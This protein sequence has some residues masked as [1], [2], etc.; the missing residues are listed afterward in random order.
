MTMALSDLVTQFERETEAEIRAIRS[1]GDAAAAQID[2]EAARVRAER[3]A[4]AGAAV[5]AELR[6]AA[7]LEIGAVARRARGEILTARAA[8]LDRIRDAI[9]GELPGLVASD[10]RLGASLVA[11]AIAC[12]GGDGGELRCAPALVEAARAAAPA[13]LRVEGDPAVAT[14]AIIEL[15]TGTRID[16]TLDA[17]LDRAWPRLACEALAMERTR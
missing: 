13:A 5:T 3:I 10:V 8:M 9:R 14:G 2:G 15:S 11:A 17:L 16:A 6:A 12:T 1:A 4:V 7:D